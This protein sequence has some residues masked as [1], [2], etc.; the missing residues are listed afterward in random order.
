MTAPG[1]IRRMLLYGMI[2][3]A[4]TFAVTP[5]RALVVASPGPAVTTEVLLYR[6]GPGGSEA[7]LQDVRWG[8]FCRWHRHHRLC[9]KFVK[10]RRF[11]D[12]RPHHRLCDDD[13]DDRFCKKRPN[14]PL[15]D[16][17]RFCKKRP[18]HPLCDDDEPPSPS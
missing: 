7:L 13:D 15:C 9:F 10:L 4:L 14:H 2:F 8:R 17:D 3:G 6:D 1:P 11:C 5:S 16:D 18:H 12:R